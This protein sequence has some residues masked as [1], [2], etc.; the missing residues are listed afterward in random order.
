M[1]ESTSDTLPPDQPGLTPLK[2]LQT[3]TA[4]EWE[5]FIE[6]WTAGFE[7]PYVQVV[8]LGGA[9]DMGRDVIGHLADTRPCPCDV[10]QCKHYDHPLRPTDAYLELGKLCVYTQRGEYPVPRRY[11]FVPPIRH[12][13]D[14]IRAIQQ[15]SQCHVIATQIEEES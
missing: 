13:S 2:F 6:E 3:F 8:R 4:D 10:Y 5:T 7:P 15:P 9:G 12:K 1:A 14:T 11:R